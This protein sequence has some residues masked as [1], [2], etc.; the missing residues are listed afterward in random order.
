MCASNK[1]QHA[2]QLTYSRLLR[3]KVTREILN[4]LGLLQRNLTVNREPELAKYLTTPETK[5]R[6]LVTK[7]R[8]GDYGVE[9]D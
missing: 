1:T 9:T 6:K 4:I 2:Q 3:G 5:Q 8:L 7:Y